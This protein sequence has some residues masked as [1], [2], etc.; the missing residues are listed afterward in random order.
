MNRPPG[1][2]IFADIEGSSGCSDRQS[3]RW[4]NPHWLAA[5]REMTRDLLAVL[6]ALASAGE[7]RVT[8]ADFHRTGYNL[9]RDL[10]PGWVTVRQGYRV[11]PVPGFGKV[12]PADRAF[13]LGMHAAGGGPGML[14]HTLTSRFASLTVNGR[15]LAEIELFA[16]SL[17]SW[18]I[19]PALFSGC[20]IA[21]EQARERIPGVAI[22]PVPPRPLTESAQAAWRKDLACAAVAVALA[23][24][25]TLPVPFQP[26]GPFMVRYQWV[27]AA[28]EE[29]FVAPDFGFLYD[30]LLT[31][32]YYPGL[33]RGWLPLGL[34]LQN[35]LG[36]HGL[37]WARFRWENT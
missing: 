12:P 17:G 26:T 13:F 11:G 27:G 2:I 21:C 8:V 9:L 36:R 15:P 19:R 3:A 5:C 10:L 18:G 31:L 20:P 35:L 22:C 30:R 28:R 32:A 37:Q 6:D 4:M 16:A 33:P 1:I 7:R 34:R 23:P 24:V 25:A 14:A 29:S